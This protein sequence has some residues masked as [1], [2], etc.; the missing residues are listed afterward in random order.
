M[1]DGNFVKSKLLHTFAETTR[2]G[3]HRQRF[4]IL[5]VFSLF[6]R[7]VTIKGTTN[8]TLNL[9]LICHKKATTKC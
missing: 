1:V 8:K 6:Q 4:G 3:F 9:W 2:E 7:N 5:L